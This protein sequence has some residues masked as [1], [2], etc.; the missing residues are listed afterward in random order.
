[1]RKDLFPE[2]IQVYYWRSICK[3]WTLQLNNNNQVK[4]KW[5][6]IQKIIKGPAWLSVACDRNVAHLR[7]LNN[8]MCS[9]FWVSFPIIKKLSNVWISFSGRS[10][11]PRAEPHPA[12]APVDSASVAFVSWLCD[13][14]HPFSRP[15]LGHLLWHGDTKYSNAQHWS[16]LV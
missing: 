14:S 15:L 5:N 6:Y 11:P 16:I 12:L 2:Q 1:M 8:E 3:T 4:Y 10:A 13:V 9:L 7:Y